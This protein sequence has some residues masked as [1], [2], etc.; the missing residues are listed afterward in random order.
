MRLR[1]LLPVLGGVALAMGIGAASS[2]RAAETLA[3]PPATEGRPNGDAPSR[4]A[5]RVAIEALRRLGA[6][7]E[8]DPSQAVQSVAA[9][10]TK[11]TDADLVH[12]EAMPELETLEI[13]GGKITDA[14]LVHLRRLI[15]LKRLY[16]RDLPISDAALEHLR[17]LKD[18]EDA[19]GTRS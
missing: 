11:I 18:L 16:L 8:F 9:V 4:E 7:I 2:S 10:K 5:Q 3:D 17:G 14:G 13:A 12:L 19:Q 1:D 15:G 6:R